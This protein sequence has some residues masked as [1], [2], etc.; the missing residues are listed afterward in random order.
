MAGTAHPTPSNPEYQHFVP[1][2]I[3]RNFAHKYTG[4]QRSKKGK[5]NKDD[6]MFRG[7]LVVNNVNLKADPIAIEETKIKRILGQYDM[8]Q[9]TALPTA[10]RREVETLLGKLET[11]VSI[12][13]R[14]ITKAFEAGDPSIWVTRE[15]RNSIRKFLFILKYRG[16]RFHQRFY[17]ESLDQYVANDK[18][19]L[20]NYMREKGFERPVDVWF[21]GL[22]T[23]MDLNMNT[24]NWHQELAKNM[25]LSDAMWFFMHTE[26]MYMAIC[27]P[28]EPGAEFILTDNS[29]NV[30]EGPNTFMQN[31]VTGE[32]METG[33][34]SFHEFAPLTPKLMIVLRSFLFPVPEEDSNPKIKAERDAQ[35]KMAVD[36]WYGAS[37]QSSLA[38]LPIN[39]PRNSYS[40]IVDGRVRLLPGEDGAKRKTDKFCFSFFPL[41]MDHVNKINHILLDN[42]YRCSNIVFA[43]KETFFTT[44]E[45]YMTYDGDL[46]KAITIDS[47][48]ERRKFLMNLA[49]LMKA[50]GST[51]KPVWTDKTANVMSEFDKMNGLQRMLQGGLLGWMITA[52]TEVQESSAPP[53]GLEFAYMSLGGSDQTL[54]ED[55]STAKRM[56][57]QRIKIDVESQGQPEDIRGH[58][59]EQLIEDYMVSYPPRT[60]LLFVKRVRLMVL[61]HHDDEYLLR[62]AAGTIVHTEESEDIIAQALHDKMTPTKLNRLMYNTAMNDIEKAK[63]PIPEDEFWQTPT[64]FAAALRLMMVRKVVFGIPGVLKGCGIAEVEKLALAHERMIRQ[65]DLKGLPFHFMDDDQKTELLTRV[66]VRKMFREVLA[67]IVADDL[68]PVLEDVLFKISYPTPP[69]KS[70][71]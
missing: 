63:D 38:D 26:M 62:L 69:M 21:H 44:L 58:K 10:Q 36:D 46:G 25:Y 67:G 3:L 34:T 1:Q 60:V 13:F 40:E 18:S 5:K 53:R 35:R 8:Y 20:E 37:Q 59:R 4:P 54:L 48:D 30:F 51:K 68:L 65:Q 29:Y 24:D 43:S 32:I 39:K 64:N 45:W 66:A 52:K 12:I 33:W 14:K 17:H 31:P 70:P 6:N 27:T 19:Q 9:N 2:F 49:T 23:I 56:L 7:E 57:K 61:N 71:I 47:A 42:S 22:K 15:E 11:Q 50:L 28:S 16:S 41:G 55:M